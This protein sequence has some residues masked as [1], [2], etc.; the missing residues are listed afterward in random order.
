M[1]YGLAADL[2][3]V[4]HLAFLIFVG[5]GALLAWRWPWL[6]PLHAAGVLWAVG[7][8]AVGFACP[9][10]GLEK[11]FRALAGEEVYGGG[12]VDH[13]VEDG[14][15]P[16]ALTPLLQALAGV[17]TVVGYAGL[18]R[19]GLRM[20]GSGRSRARTCDCRQMLPELDEWFHV[21]KR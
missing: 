14:V 5:G 8:V 6:V 19:R 18:R 11:S 1:A 20:T 13:Y 9:L 2:V 21:E 15:Y 3:V 12:F 16:E 4:F 7:S 10:T 17:A